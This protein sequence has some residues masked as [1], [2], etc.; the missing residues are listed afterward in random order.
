MGRSSIGG[1]RWERMRGA[2]LSLRTTL[3]VAAAAAVLAVAPDLA[4][5]RRAATFSVKVEGTAASSA[6]LKP[7]RCTL[8]TSSDVATFAAAPFGIRMEDLGPIMMMIALGPRHE[9]G[10]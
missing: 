9:A 8:G 5:A 10:R 6:T 1:G 2:P 7:E 3:C 4:T